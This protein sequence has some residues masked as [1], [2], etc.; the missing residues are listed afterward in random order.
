LFFEVGNAKAQIVFIG[1]EPDKFSARMK[2]SLGG[3]N[4]QALNNEMMAVGLSINDCRIYNIWNHIPPV[5]TEKEYEW[6]IERLLVLLKPAKFVALCGAAPM[7]AFWGEREPEF[8][9]LSRKSV[10]LPGKIVTPFP[11]MSAFAFAPIGELRFCIRSL[12]RELKK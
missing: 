11:A 7:K 1:E 3:R 5:R 10:R 12:V 9:G 8:L 4:L 2:V 6:N